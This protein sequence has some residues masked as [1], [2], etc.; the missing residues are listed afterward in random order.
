MTLII[1][2]ILN[3]KPNQ[4]LS[5]INLS[6][7]T[8]INTTHTESINLKNNLTLH[9]ILLVP[10]FKYNLMSIFKLLIDNQYFITFFP[11]FY[12]IKKYHLKKLKKINKQ[13]NNLY[14]LIN[15]SIENLNSKL[16]NQPLIITDTTSHL[17]NINS[18]FL[19]YI[20]KPTINTTTTSD[21]IYKL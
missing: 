20:N 9:D 19:D 6:N 12:L 2:S 3:L 13:Y 1:H 17:F 18:V 14:Y 21:D 15:N 11:K 8:I 4:N 16:K 5:K 10:N 7:N